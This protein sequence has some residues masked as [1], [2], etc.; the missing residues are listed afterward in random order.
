MQSTSKTKKLNSLPAGVPEGSMPLKVADP[1]AI[2]KAELWIL[3]PDGKLVNMATSPEKFD[4]VVTA[5]VD[6]YDRVKWPLGQRSQ[7][8]AAA[9]GAIPTFYIP[10]DSLTA[11]LATQK[12]SVVPPEPQETL[13]DTSEA[14]LHSE[15]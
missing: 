5:Y 4:A 8:I 11:D 2:E 7:L 15:E 12:A 3:A 1:E 9:N 10:Q 6:L 13:V 14:M